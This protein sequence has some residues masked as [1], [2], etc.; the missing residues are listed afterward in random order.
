MAGRLAGM[1]RL[2]EGRPGDASLRPARRYSEILAATFPPVAA[3]LGFV[4]LWEG[5]V[6]VFLIPE[7]LLPRPTR[8]IEYIAQNA[9]LLAQHAQATI[10]ATL[11]GFVI[12]LAFGIGLAIVIVWSTPFER[13]VYPLIVLTQVIPKVAVAPLIIVYM[14]F[15]LQPKIFLAFLVSFFPVVIN[16]ALG[17]KSVDPELVELLISLHATRWQVMRKVRWYRALPHIVE[18]AKIAVTLAIIGAIVGEFSAGN[19]GLGYLIASAA[20]SV[21]TTLSFA[22][23]FVL[24]IIGIVLFEAIHVVGLIITPWIRRG[25][26]VERPLERAA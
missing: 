25:P 22:S 19:V 20:S 15:G 13:A 12:A 11:L 7:F 18:A 3:L 2:V 23:L 1:R 24:I 26:E 4:A 5:V 14:G 17:L 21:N 10:L 6:R 9:A 8:I 16:T